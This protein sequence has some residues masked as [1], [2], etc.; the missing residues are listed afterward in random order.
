MQTAPSAKSRKAERRGLPTE[1]EP[2]GLR[3]VEGVESGER[4]HKAE[5]PSMRKGRLEAVK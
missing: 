4:R 3:D 5:M 1:P 2:A